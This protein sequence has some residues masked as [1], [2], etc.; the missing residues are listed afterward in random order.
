M[1]TTKTLKD[2]RRILRA[3]ALEVVD[4]GDRKEMIRAAHILGDVPGLEAASD[5]LTQYAH[6]EEKNAELATL[7][8]NEIDNFIKE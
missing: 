3:I 5:Y 1:T 6:G 8:V 2:A 4:T 7:F